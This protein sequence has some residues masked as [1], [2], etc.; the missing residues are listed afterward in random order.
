TFY[1]P[2]DL[3]G[4]TG[5][6]SGSVTGVFFPQGYGYPSTIDVVI[7]F[8]G[9][10]QQWNTIQDF[11]KPKNGHDIT[12]REDVNSSGKKVVLIAPTMGDLPGYSGNYTG[13]LDQSGKSADLLL[14]NVRDYMKQKV[15][16]YKDRKPEIGNIVL[17]AHSGGGETLLRQTLLMSR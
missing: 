14:D 9:N 2:I 8:H 4:A 15:P 12:L 6:D 7:F 16:Q 17:A 5:A 1:F 11:W 10:K 13:A 3:G